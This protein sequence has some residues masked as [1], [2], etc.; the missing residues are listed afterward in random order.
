MKELIRDLL[1]MKLNKHHYFTNMEQ[2]PQ[3]KWLLEP[4]PTC[5]RGIYLLIVS[6]NFPPEG[7]YSPKTFPMTV[8]DQD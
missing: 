3:W 8:V 7:K 1:A 6:S 5:E 2:D 4:I